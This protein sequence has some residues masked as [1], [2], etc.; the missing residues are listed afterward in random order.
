M[1]Q[2]SE[3]YQSNPLDKQTKSKNNNNKHIIISLDAEKALDE[4]QHPAIIKVL[5]RSRIQGPYLKHSKSNIQKTSSQ[6]ETKWRE[7]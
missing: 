2:Y 6:R 1:I 3:I 7:T 4:I 5:E